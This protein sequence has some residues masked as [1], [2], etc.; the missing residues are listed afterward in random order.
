MVELEATYVYFQFE[1]YETGRRGHNYSS[2][3]G[4]MAKLEEESSNEEYM[5]T[6][7]EA[8]LVTADSIQAQRKKSS[9]SHQV[10]K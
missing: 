10:S 2:D 4:V 7:E 1:V 6:P 9:V 8:L 5:D 3:V